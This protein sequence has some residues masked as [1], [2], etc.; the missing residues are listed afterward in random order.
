MRGSL[1]LGEIKSSRCLWFDIVVSNHVLELTRFCQMRQLFLTPVCRILS[2][3][4]TLMSTYVKSCKM[5][6]YQKLSKDANICQILQKTSMS[7]SVKWCEIVHWHL[8]FTCENQ[9]THANLLT[10]FDR[11]WHSPSLLLLPTIVH[12]PTATTTT[13]LPCYL[14]DYNNYYHYAMLD[15]LG[16][17]HGGCNGS[18]GSTRSSSRLLPRWCTST[19]S[20]HKPK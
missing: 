15:V 4:D 1:T 20:S 17:G 6:S 5:L 2:N 14:H 11:N 10:W 8:R 9:S 3:S 18:S 16:G 13:T 19:S 12:F 7:N